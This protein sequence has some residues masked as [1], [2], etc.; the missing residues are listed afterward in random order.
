MQTS[1]NESAETC[2]S[3]TSST[4]TR[5]ADRMHRTLCG[6]CGIWW[7]FDAESDYVAPGNCL[8]CEREEASEEACI[9]CDELSEGRDEAQGALEEAEAKLKLAR[10]KIESLKNHAG[11]APKSGRSRAFSDWLEKTKSLIG[12][13]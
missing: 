12:D 4:E 11:L 6:R 5:R 1:K 8:R 9:G 10:Q 13:L 3:N 7:Y 2:T